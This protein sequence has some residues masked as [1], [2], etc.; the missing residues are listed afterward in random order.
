MAEKLLKYYKY[1]YD[2][3]SLEGRIELAKKTNVPTPRAA[4]EQDSRENIEL[5]RKAIR[6]L[7]GTDAPQY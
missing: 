5:F 4:M 1:I 7:T 3:K 2:L 6:E